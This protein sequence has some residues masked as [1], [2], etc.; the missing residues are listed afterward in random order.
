MLILSKCSLKR[1][2]VLSALVI[3][4]NTFSVVDSNRIVAKSIKLSEGLRQNATNLSDAQL[5]QIDKLI[6]DALKVSTG[7][8]V[9]TGSGTDSRSPLRCVAKD[10]D[11]MDP[12]VLGVRSIEFTRK[13][14]GT[15]V[16]DKDECMLSAKKSIIVGKFALACISKDSD[17]IAPWAMSKISI[18]NATSQIVETTETKTLADCFEMIDKAV[19]LPQG[20][21]FCSTKDNDGLAPWIRVSVLRDGSLRK[22]QETYQKLSDCQMSL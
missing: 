4:V 2:A 5:T 18:E 16:G 17:G 9:D 1:I 10:D 14:K 12:W 13:V 15:K 21:M 20:V 3:S 6:S 7:Q 8:I 11:N 19:R 22:S